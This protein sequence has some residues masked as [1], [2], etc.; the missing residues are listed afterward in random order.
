MQQGKADFQT[1]LL[2]MLTSEHMGASAIGKSHSL[3]TRLS[4]GSSPTAPTNFSMTGIKIT[5][6]EQKIINLLLHGFDNKAIAAEIGIM[7][8]TV[9]AHFNRLFLKFRIETGIKRVKLAVLLF[10]RQRCKINTVH[11]N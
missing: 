1:Q 8:R 7:P 10:R 4:V 5:S 11:V 6:V 2:F 9:K 3:R